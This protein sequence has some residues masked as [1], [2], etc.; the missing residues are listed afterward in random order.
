M[1]DPGIFFTANALAKTGSI[2]TFMT[3]FI[4]NYKGGRNESFM[5]G[6]DKD[7]KWF[8]Y[9]L[10]SAYTTAMAALT[11]PDYFAGD[12]IDHNKVIKWSDAQLM[13]GYTIIYTLFT[14]PKSVKYP[15][16][17]C[18]IDKTSTVYPLVGTSYL[19]GP[20]F[21]LARNQGCEFKPKLAFHI[22][23]KKEFSKSDKEYISLKPFK[24]IIKELQRLR[25]LY[26]KKTV[27]NLTYKEIGNSIYGNVVRGMNNKLTFDSKTGN[28][29]RII[30]TDLSNPIL[31]S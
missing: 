9:D 20:E 22:A 28:S 10:T 23:D 13:S 2:G 7:T 4:N 17:P 31:A 5:Y 14:F 6:I 27:N 15:S 1:G 25:K 19:T 30:G 26:P 3:L 8:D 18:Y 12:I 11:L 29:T 24:E 21:I 16:I